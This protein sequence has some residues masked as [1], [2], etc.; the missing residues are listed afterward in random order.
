MIEVFI[1]G[2]SIGCGKYDKKGGW[3]CRLTEFIYSRKKG[4]LVYN[5]SIDGNITEDLLKRFENEVKN[6]VD[7]ED[8]AIFI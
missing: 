7:G 2:D 4:T 3:A 1:F 8:E 6:R 5:L